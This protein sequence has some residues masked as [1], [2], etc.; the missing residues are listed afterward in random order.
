MNGFGL[1]SAC[2]R[3]V[4]EDA[5]TQ[6]I[7][8]VSTCTTIPEHPKPAKRR[9][10]DSG[11]NRR[12]PLNTPSPT[13]SSTDMPRGR[14]RPGGNGLDDNDDDS[15]RG[16]GQGSG[17]IPS[18]TNPRLDLRPIALPQRPSSHQ[19]RRKRSTSPIKSRRD[20]EKLVK[21]VYIYE[22]EEETAANVLPDD[23]FPLY[24][25]ILN[26]GEHHVGV[27]PTVL[28]D[29]IPAQDRIPAHSF[30][31][32]PRT[33]PAATAES[34]LST[35]LQIK[36]DAAL[37]AELQR[38]EI[39]W[40]IIVHSPVLRLALGPR[41]E[42]ETDPEPQILRQQRQH[43]SVRV[44]PIMSAPI[45]PDSVPLLDP[46][47]TTSVGSRTAETAAWTASESSTHVTEGS[48]Q[49]VD[50]ASITSGRSETKKVD[51]VLVLDIAK[52]I[53]LYHTISRLIQQISIR[54]GTKAHVNQTDYAPIF[55]NPIAVSIETKSASSSRDPLLQLGIWTAS[56]HKRMTDL[57]TWLLMLN[58]SISGVSKVS[59]PRLVSVPLVVVT[60][61][62]WELY[63]ACEVRLDDRPNI[64]IHGP[65]SLGSTKTTLKMFSLVASLR[66][67]KRWA[68][69]TFYEAVNSWF[70][71]DN[72]SD[73]ADDPPINDVP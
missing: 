23:I 28:R 12:I 60:G 42:R 54:D 51:Y 24:E 10:L 21:P 18:G 22:L 19:N 72:E 32:E 26:I 38:H 52:E 4:D 58:G 7:N 36:A 8:D 62:H 33:D 14:K 2:P 30:G 47:L 48:Q 3:I 35:I 20:L 9:R 45:S 13:D 46:D 39:A 70:T 69:G 25:E 57:R 41:P 1:L 55:R 49:S 43:V 59:H 11:R 15:Y 40:N 50:S 64:S 67:I 31:D 56:W 66:A 27:I 17:V 53:P 37:S 34:A 5:I 16:S 71:P 73:S 6:W 29:R 44:E 68:E 61:H 63:F 65:V